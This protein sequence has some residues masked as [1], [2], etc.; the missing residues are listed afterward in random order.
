MTLISILH[1]NKEFFHQYLD[2]I[3]STSASTL[4]LLRFSSALT[5]EAASSASNLDLLK[6]L[7]A[8][9]LDVANSDSILDL[10]NLD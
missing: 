7:S 6:A 10:L 2:R 1:Q 5:L 4:I 9:I 3:L 8:T